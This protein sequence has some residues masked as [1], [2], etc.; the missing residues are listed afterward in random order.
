MRMLLALPLVF[1]TSSLAV[2]AGGGPVPVP[3]APSGAK[4]AAGAEVRYNEGEAL[5]HQQR[6]KDAEA[7]YR[8]ATSLR[9]EFPQAWNGLGH[10]LKMQQ[11]YPEALHAYQEALRLR[12]EY[13]QALEYL[14]E[15]Y[16]AMGRKDDALGT[17]A[18]LKP[19]DATLA[20]T[21]E[22][23]IDGKKTAGGW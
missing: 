5:A 19:L 1:V 14:G 18:K 2:A 20:A 10:A 11:R 9:A 17:L 3:P 13:P 22:A 7:A 6:W 21:L 16:V 12:P 23:V 8:D 15:T 4:P